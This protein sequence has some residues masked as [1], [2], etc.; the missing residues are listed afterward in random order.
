[1]IEEESSSWV[2]IALSNFLTILHYFCVTPKQCLLGL[3]KF[4][5]GIIT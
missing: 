5:N 1:M 4:V 3:I 2:N